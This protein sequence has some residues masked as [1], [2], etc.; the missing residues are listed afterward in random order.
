MSQKSYLFV[1][2]PCGGKDATP[3]FL[4]EAG[5][6]FN[7]FGLGDFLRDQEEANPEASV[8]YASLM[9]KGRNLPDDVIEQILTEQIPLIDNDKPLI[10]I[11]APRSVEQVAI[12]ISILHKNGFETPI[13]VD[14]DYSA[15]YCIGMHAAAE[16]RKER[17]HRKDGAMATFRN[18]L[19]LFYTS[20]PAIL[21]ECR[22]CELKIYTIND[23]EKLDHIQKYIN[24]LGLSVAYRGHRVAV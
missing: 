14:F 10:I 24:D 16:E 3:G 6:V 13:V 5:A 19:N 2:P 11:G 1:G 17:E 18:R 4:K 22:A 15:D 20:Q 7:T 9:D 8:L 21:E 12:L 23:D